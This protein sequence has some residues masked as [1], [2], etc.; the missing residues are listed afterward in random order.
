MSLSL[1]NISIGYSQ[2]EI[3]SH[4]NAQLEKGSLCALL[5]KNG[6]GKTTLLKTLL[7]FIPPL[8]GE[9]Y[10]EGI[11]TENYNPPNFSRKVSIVL[12]QAPTS[13]EIRVEDFILHGRYPYHN[14]QLRPLQYEESWWKEIEGLLQL[15]E[16]RGKR[17]SELSDGN[18]QK[19]KIA[20]AMAQNTS[21]IL[22]DEPLSHLDISNQQ[23]IL[24]L[25]QYLAFEKQKIILFSAH[26]WMQSS[27]V[28]SHLWVIK[29]HQLISGSTED[30]ALESDLI[31]LFTE[32]DYR[33]D[34]SLHQYQI[35]QPQLQSQAV[36]IENN[37]N[38]PERE[39]WLKK[40]MQ[41]KG[42]PLDEDAQIIITIEDSSYRLSQANY[43]YEFTNISKLIQQ[44]L[45]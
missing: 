18:F 23:M 30:V 5:G 8:K 3:L 10:I 13:L 36:C 29:D 41:R 32:Q 21:I 26:D 45:T 17:V 11:P 7:N 44:L 14:F 40:A 6:S 43:S 9:V 42:I 20:R 27:S 37:S 31:S 35:A 39:F 34:F 1:K 19:I 22:L 12:S 28:A 25:L 33:F 4:V 16:I 38:Q 2:K 24:D 15:E